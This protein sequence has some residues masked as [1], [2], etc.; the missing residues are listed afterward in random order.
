M[1]LIINTE[2]D[3]V[4]A[5]YLC[6][7]VTTVVR[8]THIDTFIACVLAEEISDNVDSYLRLACV[9]FTFEHDEVALGHR[10]E[11]IDPHMTA[12]ELLIVGLSVNLSF[13]HA[14][15]KVDTGLTLLLCQCVELAPIKLNLEVCVIFY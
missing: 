6:L 12:N 3:Q 4:F 15:A 2:S 9:P 1:R 14:L 11:Q 10:P 13:L 8:H 5:A 7:Y